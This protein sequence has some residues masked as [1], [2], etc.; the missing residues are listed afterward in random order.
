[1]GCQSIIC[2]NYIEINKERRDLNAKMG[3]EAKNGFLLSWP[4]MALTKHG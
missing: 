2:I 3:K 4:N 1:M